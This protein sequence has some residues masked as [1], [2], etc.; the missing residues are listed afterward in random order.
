MKIN[1]TVSTVYGNL[2]NTSYIFYFF[3]IIINNNQ[4]LKFV[5][6]KVKNNV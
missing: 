5:I 2:H 3:I 6:V 4:N 1:T